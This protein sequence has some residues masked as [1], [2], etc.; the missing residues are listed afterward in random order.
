[1]NSTNIYKHKR[2]SILNLTTT[3]K[4]AMCYLAAHL[5]AISIVGMVYLSGLFDVGFLSTESLAVKLGT[6]VIS[7]IS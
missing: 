2:H 6:Y 5:T 1:M 4:L 7:I 3:M